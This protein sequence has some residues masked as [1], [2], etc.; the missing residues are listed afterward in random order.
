[1]NAELVAWVRQHRYLVP[2]GSDDA[3]T[4]ESGMALLLLWEVDHGRSFVTEGGAEPT[5]RLLSFTRR[6]QKRAA[7][8]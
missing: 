7:G 5:L 6:L 8:P 2:A 4:W 1:M 3:T